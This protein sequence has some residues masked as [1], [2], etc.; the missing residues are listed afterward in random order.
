MNRAIYR[1]IET[2]LFSSFSI[3]TGNFFF[4]ISSASILWIVKGLAKFFLGKVFIFLK[5]TP[6]I[7]TLIFQVT[8]GGGNES[9]DIC[10]R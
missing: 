3:E 5:D 4:V 2:C 6:L 9:N 10:E 7:Y 1:N 8:S